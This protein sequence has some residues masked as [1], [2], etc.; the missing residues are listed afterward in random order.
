M[1]TKY[2]W[3]VCKFN[4]RK[5]SFVSCACC[6]ESELEYRVGQK[7]IPHFGKIFIFETRARAREFSKL[8]RILNSSNFYIFKVLAENPRPLKKRIYSFSDL[9][10]LIEFWNGSFTGAIVECPTGTYRA[11]SVTV[12]EKSK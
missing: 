10:E 8:W 6:E 7:T 9:D 11:D 2:Y 4:P 12:I 1:K 3:K 5:Q